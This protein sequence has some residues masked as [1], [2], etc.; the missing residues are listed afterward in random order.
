MLTAKQEEQ[1]SRAY[2]KYGAMLYRIGL[3]HTG[4]PA[5]AEDILHDIFLRYLGKAPP[6]RDELHEKRWFVRVAVN[7]C[8]NRRNRAA[9]RR[10]VPLPETLA[11]PEFVS[12]S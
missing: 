11:A 7:L 5:D 4:S 12:D 2:G 1:F 6:F 8:H 9:A 3:T 10:N